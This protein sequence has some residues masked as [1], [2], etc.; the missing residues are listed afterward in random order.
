MPQAPPEQ[1]GSLGAGAIHRG[2]PVTL[3][4]PPEQTPQERTQWE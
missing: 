4:L 3:P 1:Y 2:A